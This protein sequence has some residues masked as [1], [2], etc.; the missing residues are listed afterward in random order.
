MTILNNKNPKT[1]SGAEIAIYEYLLIISPNE[2]TGLKALAIKDSF[3]EYG[4][5]NAA[6]QI[7]HITLVNFVQLNT[8]EDRIIYRLESFAKSI[9]PFEVKLDGFG[10]FPPQTIFI[11][12]ATKS[13]IVNM[14]KNMKKPFKHLLQ[15][16]QQD[17]AHFFANPHL[18]I[19]RELIKSQHNRAWADWQHREFKANFQASEMVLLRREIGRGKYHVVKRI[20]FGGGQGA[21]EQLM[22]GF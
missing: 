7:P 10:Q 14:V 4:C 1:A 18:T 17:P 8:M 19:T 6:N 3:K 9:K 5:H 12:V 11:N 15:P 22:L 13:P 20:P 16:H 2:E 21:G